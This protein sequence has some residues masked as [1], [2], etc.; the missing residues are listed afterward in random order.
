MKKERE[1]ER[2]RRRRRKEKG[3]RRVSIYEIGHTRG[4][5]IR[6]EEKEEKERK[7]EDKQKKRSL[8]N[9]RPTPRWAHPAPHPQG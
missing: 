9:R 3:N 2:R 5:E 8:T 7:K 6:E 1:R 4:E